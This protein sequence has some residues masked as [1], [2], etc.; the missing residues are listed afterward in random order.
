MKDF[1]L[2]VE[3]LLVALF[4]IF[5]ILLVIFRKR[6]FES[7]VDLGSEKMGFV[8]KSNAFALGI[9]GLLALGVLGASFLMNSTLQNISSQET[10]ITTLTEK[11][12]SLV[13]RLKQYRLT[14]DLV[15]TDNRGKRVLFTQGD[16][17]RVFALYD[18]VTEKEITDYKFT[19]EG[20]IKV[21]LD[22]VRIGGAVVFSV[23]HKL[24]RSISSETHPTFSSVEVNRGN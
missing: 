17:P 13:E 1:A 15:V 23:L 6:L 3:V 8:I 9:L 20:N 7:S 10:K 11:Y 14:F 5:L 19:S 22:D 24:G 18:N 21:G 16:T 12:D 2:V 4:T